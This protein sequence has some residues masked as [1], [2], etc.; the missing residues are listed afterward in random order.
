MKLEYNI[1][2]KRWHTP[3]GQPC[4]QLQ[5]IGLVPAKPVRDF[6]PGEFMG[7]NFGSASKVERIEPVGKAMCDVYSI[8]HAKPRR[9]KLDRLVAVASAKWRVADDHGSTIICASN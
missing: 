3:D 1:H 2:T 4:I 7:W 5:A 8:Q 6:K 9:M